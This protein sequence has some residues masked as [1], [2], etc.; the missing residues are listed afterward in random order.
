[1]RLHGISIKLEIIV[2]LTAAEGGEIGLVPDFEEPLA[3]FG[4]AVALDPMRDKLADQHRP[5][6]VIL[7]WRDVC[8]IVEYGLGA[9]R[10]CRRHETELDEWPHADRKQKIE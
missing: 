2:L 4:Q 3:D 6:R 10:Q 5:A 1:D 8:A 7:G 9:R